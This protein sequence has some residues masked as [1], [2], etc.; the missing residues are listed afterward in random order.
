MR[1]VVAGGTGFVGKALVQRLLEGGHRVTVLSRN[2]N[3]LNDLPREN[4]KIEKWNG[5]SLDAWATCIDGADAVVNLAGESIAAKRWSAEQ[6]S[7][8]TGSRLDAT[9]VIV[10][11]IQKAVQKP[12]ILINASGAGYYGNVNERSVDEDFPKGVGFLADTCETWENEAKKAEAFGIRVVL[13][14]FGVILEKD[15]GALGK[16]I[17]PFK[18]F[19][20][21]PL[22]SGRQIFPWVHREDV[23]GAVIY[24]IQNIALSGPVNVAAPEVVSMKEFCAALGAVMHR[25]SWLPVPAFALKILLGEMAEEML[26]SGVRVS[27]K[28]TRT[29]RLPF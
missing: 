16:F 28:K 24:S 11:A 26:L 8:I 17:F 13:L 12:K 19:A 20:G 2:E 25:P 3:I 22:G 18:I 29:S 15:G 4:L 23:I 27:P 7:T 14:R 10:N 5:K 6:K 9:R 1:I 21:G